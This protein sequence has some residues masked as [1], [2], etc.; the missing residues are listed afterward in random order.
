[1]LTFSRVQMPNST[2][3]IQI[4]GLP[5]SPVFLKVLKEKEENR[6]NLS[7]ATRDR[8]IAAYA[9]ELDA[10]GDPIANAVGSTFTDTLAGRSIA[11]RKVSVQQQIKWVRKQAIMIYL[12]E[13]QI[14]KDIQQIPD[15]LTDIDG[16]V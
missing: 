16:E 4:D 8:A 15:N 5:D 7:E 12:S 10:S 3:A 9:Q 1:M 14:Q 6:L 11:E 13:R 2:W